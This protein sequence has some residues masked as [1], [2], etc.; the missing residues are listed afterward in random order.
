[1]KDL[2]QLQLLGGVHSMI[3]SGKI[4]SISALAS[5]LGISRS[6]LYIYIEELELLGAKG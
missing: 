4:G 5:S 1:M 6:T 2:K 3:S